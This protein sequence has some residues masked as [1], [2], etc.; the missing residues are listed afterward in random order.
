MLRKVDLQNLSLANELYTVQQKSYTIEAELIGFLDIPPLKETFDELLSCQEEFI[1]YF[2]DE[3][4]VG[5]VSYSLEDETVHI[6]RLIVDPAHF[7][8]GIA[9]KLL[10]HLQNEGSPE[11]MIVSTGKDNHPAISLYLK[12]G[13]KLIRDIE[14]AP[15]FYLS[16]FEKR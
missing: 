8:K 16:L 15:G 9:Q 13:F 12:N 3:K 14:A 7:R 2:I 4:L 6:C 11:R 1:G 5:A 10:A